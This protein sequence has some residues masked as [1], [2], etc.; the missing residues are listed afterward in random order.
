MT[1]AIILFGAMVC[2]LTI[3]GGA[4]AQSKDEA[5]CAQ[6]FGAGGA[7]YGRCLNNRARKRQENKTFGKG[8]K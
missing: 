8:K 2:C 4:S 6:R 3:S 1:R 7:A 5:V